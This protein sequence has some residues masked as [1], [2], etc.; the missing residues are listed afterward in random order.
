MPVTEYTWD[1]ATDSILEE[2]D[3]ASNVLASYTNEPSPYGPLIGQRSGGETRYFHF[4][5]LGSTRELTDEAEDVT[6]TFTYDAWGNEVYRSG[7]SETEFHWVGRFGYRTPSLEARYS[8]RTRLYS[9]SSA[10]W[11]VVDPRRFADGLQDYMYSLNRPTTNLDP[12]GLTAVCCH[13]QVVS[14]G[15]EVDAAPFFESAVCLRSP[16]AQCCRKVC[17]ATRRGEYVGFSPIP[18]GP[19]AT[20]PMAPPPAPTR[21]GYG[22]YCGPGRKANCLENKCADGCFSR[23]VP[24]YSAN[25]APIDELDAICELHDCCL[26]TSSQAQKCWNRCKD[27]LCP[28]VQAIDCYAMYPDPQF[29]EQNACV[30]MKRQ[31]LTLFC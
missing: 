9:Q 23:W 6:D 31:F 21:V 29:A 4:D 14:F 25:P 19:P 2:T 24:N 11:S 7:N 17:C 5:A 22:H 26:A 15:P 8:I 28:M 18:P 16:P 13:C 3:G 30:T 1:S 20:R 10:R 27:E 12:S